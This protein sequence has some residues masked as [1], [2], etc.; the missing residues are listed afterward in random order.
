MGI[1]HLPVGLLIVL[2]VIV[3]VAAAPAAFVLVAVVG[4]PVMPS[5]VFVVGHVVSVVG[6]RVVLRVG[7]AKRRHFLESFAR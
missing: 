4:L 2:A 5:A 1:L 6:Q 3:V 7:S